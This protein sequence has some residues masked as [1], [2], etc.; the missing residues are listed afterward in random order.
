MALVGAALATLGLIG[1]K[2]KAQPVAAPVQNNA[3]PTPD[4][5]V[6]QE[7]AQAEVKRK[8]L[9][10]QRSQTI[11]TSPLGIGGQ[12]EVAKTTLGV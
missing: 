7:K 12:A 5:A 9:A 8:Q 11:F 10:R 2:Q 4:P 1:G 3:A 6:A